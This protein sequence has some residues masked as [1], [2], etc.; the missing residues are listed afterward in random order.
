MLV[1]VA[2]QEAEIWRITMFEDSWGKKVLKTP[3]QP[4]K[5]GYSGARLSLHLCRK[6]K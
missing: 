3:S 4:I 6:Y 5:A 2:R 1:I